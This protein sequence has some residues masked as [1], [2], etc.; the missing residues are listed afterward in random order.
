MIPEPSPREYQPDFDDEERAAAGAANRKLA[1]GLA[2]RLLAEFKV[3]TPPV[4]VEA[5]IAGRGLSVVTVSEAVPLSGAL[6]REQREIVLNVLGRPRTRQRFT[7]A[8]ELGH[9]ELRHS[10]AGDA[11]QDTIG[12]DGPFGDD[13]RSQPKDPREVEANAFAA[14]LLMPSAWIRR[15]PKGLGGFTPEGLA[16]EYEVSLEAMFYQL[17]ACGR[18]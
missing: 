13:E 5:I 12:F 7:L 18:L 4:P 17:M 9:W 10:P 11:I 3:K 16:A 14:E 6:Y 15:L 2:K 1:L 8:H